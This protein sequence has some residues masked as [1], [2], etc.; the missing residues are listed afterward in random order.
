M[1]SILLSYIVFY[2]ILAFLRSLV[3]AISHIQ[4]VGW[5]LEKQQTNQSFV[6]GNNSGYII[7]VPSYTDFNK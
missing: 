1:E 2:Q 3:T 7:V 5:R 4:Y 6:D